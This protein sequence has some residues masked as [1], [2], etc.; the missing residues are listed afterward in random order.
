MDP[1]QVE[2]DRFQN[3]LDLL[4]HLIRGV[5]A[6]GMLK[7]LQERELIEV[8]GRADGLGRPLLYGST[9]RFIDHFGFHALTD[10][11][12]PEELPVVLN[13]RAEPESSRAA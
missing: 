11:P 4:L 12:R 7:T 8:V 10:L 9:R 5:G 3:P 2:L 13:R 1:F 6:G